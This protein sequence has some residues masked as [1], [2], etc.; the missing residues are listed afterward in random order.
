[1]TNAETA[2]Q[3][4]SP[5]VARAT[6]LLIG[7]CREVR[8]NQK[9]IDNGRLCLLVPVLAVIFCNMGVGSGKIELEDV[10]LVSFG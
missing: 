10:R 7:V 6:E 8:A 2:L 1:M 9:S 5:T 3:N 4:V